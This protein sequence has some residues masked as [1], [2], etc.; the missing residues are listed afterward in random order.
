[1]TSDLNGCLSNKWSNCPTLSQD[2]LWFGGRG[3]EHNEGIYVSRSRVHGEIRREWRVVLDLLRD[4]DTDLFFRIS[5][6]MLNYLCW[7]GRTAAQ[8]LVQSS[9]PNQPGDEKMVID[10]NRPRRRIDFI[11]SYELSNKTF[12]IAAQSL[13]D[14]EILSYIQKWIQ[15]DKLSFLVQVVNRH[16]ALPVVIDALRRYQ[17]LRLD[18]MELNS[19][20]KRG[21]RVAL[22]RRFLSDQ[23]N[24][25][26]VAK[27][28]LEI[29][30]FCE[31]MKNLVYTEDSHGKLGGKSASLWLATQIL[32]KAD[33]PG[34]LLSGVK[35]PKTW[36]ITSDVLSHFIHYNNLD[37]VVEQK[38]KSIDQVRQEYPDIV[39]TFI[40]S[41]IPSDIV[42]GLSV[43]LDDFGDRPLIVRS[44]S[45]LED[46]IG[47]AFV[48]KYRSLFLSNQG[49]KAERL[50]ALSR[51]I[52]E[53]YASTFSPEP[54]AYRVDRKLIDFGE[55]MGIIIQEV[56]GS[57]VG[58][59]F[60]P[61][62]AGVALS[63][64]DFRW[65]PRIKR[66]D[67][68]LR[69][70]SGLG[71]RAVNHLSDDFA[72]LLV[73]GQ[74]K[75]RVNTTFED[76]LRYAPQKMDVINLNT[77]SVQTLEIS[78]LLKEF[79]HDFPGIDQ[80]FSVVTDEQFLRPVNLDVDFEQ[81]NVPAT[82]GGLASSIQFMKQ[83][84]T[85]LH[86]LEDKLERPVE[87]ELA[88]D[89]RDLYLLGCRPQS[90]TRVARPAPIPQNLPKDKSGI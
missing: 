89:G 27:N 63:R 20:T 74:P 21:V 70:V 85:I 2:F 50:K 61:A 51:A 65:S 78:T 41:D 23:L 16:L 24:F 8:K 69:L 87:I 3:K 42:N 83:V 38:Y 81:N 37:D 36:Y 86:V 35:T 31:L 11:Y 26:R 40:N 82:F 18:N 59:Y 34:G 7:N 28:S 66:K 12:E 53:V 67:G 9:Q 90:H 33:D 73:P 57:R 80:V 47:V 30:D 68:M 29:G 77:N 19:P 72:A 55:E 60:F 54:I 52:S 39:Q 56:V 58:N 15:E 44:S 10:L 75:L 32:K 49:S 1:M 76:I 45:L 62:F 14:D 17:R 6:K 88:S 13:N 46:R 5:R 43:A 79:G 64:N 22:I 48:G 4:T 71:T 84:S 25:I